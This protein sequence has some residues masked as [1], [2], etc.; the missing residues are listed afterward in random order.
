M[1]VAVVDDHVLFR[2]GVRQTLASSARYELVGEAS[3]AREAFKMVDAAT[4]DI[5]LMDIGL[6]GMDGVVATREIRRRSPQTRILIITAYAEI[7]NVLDALDAGAAGF[8]LKTDGPEALLDALARIQRGER[9]LAPGVADRLRA[10]EAR[11]RH[12]TDVLSVLSQRER[13][14]FRLAVKCL[15]AR[16]IAQELCIARKTVDT[17]LNRINRKLALRNQ[18]EL[19]RLGANLGM[20]D[21]VRTGMP[22]REPLQSV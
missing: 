10:V 11:R 19:V 2:V 8:A 7:N 22:E 13:E 6:P 15:K 16:E 17:H 20:V 18:A 1:K 14:I 3:S 5:L 21:T 4:P 12:V 9:Y